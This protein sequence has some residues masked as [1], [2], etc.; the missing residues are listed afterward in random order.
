MG[1]RALGRG[2]N[3]LMPGASEPSTGILEVDIDA[4]MPNP[5]QPRQQLDDE[6]LQELAN[7]IRESGVI[8]PLVVRR[9]DNR[10]EIV[11]GERRWRAAQLAGL[12]KVPVVVRDVSDEEQ[13][14]LALIENIQRE[15]LN[16]VEEASAYQSMVRDFHMTQEEIATRVGKPRATIANYLR[17]LKL[18]EPIQAMLIREELTM[19]HAK[20]LLGLKNPREQVALARRVAR[21]GWTVRKLEAWVQK[22]REQRPPPKVEDLSADPDWEQVRRELEAYLGAQVK[23]RR[24]G[25]RGITLQI[26]FP[27]WEN[28]DDFYRRLQML[29]NTG[30]RKKR[31]D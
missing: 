3:A 10:Y 7:S 27:G 14:V 28:V 2:L 5:L 23:I 6:R 18:P 4:L 30:K 12:K 8:Q 24:R 29:Y 26:M 1:R 25:K 20:A 31:D 16:P 11:A 15:D 13:L 19:G 17:L 9:R 22:R 21:E